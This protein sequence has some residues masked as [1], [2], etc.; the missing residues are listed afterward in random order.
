MRSTPRTRTAG[1]VALLAL[2]AALAFGACAPRNAHQGSN[3]GVSGGQTTT[4]T[5]GQNTS[6]SAASNPDIQSVE[7]TDNSIQ[8]GIQSLNSA[9]NDANTDYS[10]QDNPTVP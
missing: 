9:S 10:S 4:Q 3:S 1:F 5:S 7:N 6:S 8:G 2:L